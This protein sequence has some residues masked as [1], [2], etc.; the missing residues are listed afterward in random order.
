MVPE[1]WTREEDKK[2]FQMKQFEQATS[3]KS[4]PKGRIIFLITCLVSFIFSLAP[5]HDY[6]VYQSYVQGSCVI[7]SASVTESHSKSSTTYN[8]H[9]EFT[10]HTT[11]GQFYA[12]H[13]TLGGYSTYDEAQ[14]ALPQYEVGSTYQCWYNPADPTRA[15]LTYAPYSIGLALLYAILAFVGYGLFIGLA[16]WVIVLLFP[17][18]S[19]VLRGQ[20]TTG[21]IVAYSGSGRSRRAVVSYSIEG[22][23]HDIQAAINGPVGKTIIVLFDPRGVFKSVARSE[24]Y[25]TNF[26]LLFLVLF[27]FGAAFFF[28]YWSWFLAV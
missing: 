12:S 27:M 8:L 16:L 22:R 4:F 7:T 15:G 5:I 20:R 28:A 26:W 17:G 24:A 6:Y 21:T 11:G 25:W 14:A 3:R 13:S 2:E 1:T 9:Y 23:T 19:L 10:V 18:L